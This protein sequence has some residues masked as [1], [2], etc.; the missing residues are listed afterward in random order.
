MLGVL[1]ISTG[2]IFRQYV[3]E[4]TELGKE[5][6]SY[7]QKGLLVPDELVVKLISDRLDR[8]DAKKG[9]ILDGYPRTK[10]QAIELDKYLNS[11]GKR[12]DYCI[13]LDVEY[14]I[15]LSRILNRRICNN[16][17]C[18]EIYNLEFKKPKVEGFCD[19]C[20][21]PLVQRKDDTEEVFKQRLDVYER[22]APEIVNYYKNAG[23]LFTYKI[24]SENHK[25]SDEVA[26]E[27]VH[28]V[29]GEKNGNN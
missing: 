13:Y 10:E 12:I 5:L 17:T 28:L 21:S 26:Q 8:E 15:I 22:T 23:K 19:K 18:H 20:G 25:T 4:N 14:D 2:D 29:R 24:T 6:E 16:Q 27:F 9:A 7:M 11:I 3:N 1:H